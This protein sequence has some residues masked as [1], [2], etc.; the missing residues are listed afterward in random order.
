MADVIEALRSKD[1]GPRTNHTI[2]VQALTKKYIELYDRWE[3]A[4]NDARRKRT[5]ADNLDNTAATIEKE[6]WVLGEKL[7]AAIGFF[8]CK[9][10][11]EQL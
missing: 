5:E 4:V 9:E 7:H 11:R 1:F 3:S 2:D 10:V 8:D 6:L